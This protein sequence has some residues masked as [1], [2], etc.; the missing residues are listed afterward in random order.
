MGL[1]DT[2]PMPKKDP[3][4]MD[5]IA[6]YDGEEPDAG[7]SQIK[8]SVDKVQKLGVRTEPAAMRALDKVVKAVGRIEV[9]ER[10]VFA[11]RAQVRRL[12]GA[13]VRQRHR[14]AGQQGPAAV[15]GLQPGTG[16]RAARICDRH[17]GG[18][19]AE[20]RRRRSAGRHEAPRRLEPGPAARTGTSPK[21]RCARW[22][23][24]GRRGARS[25]SARRCP[26]SSWKRRPSRACASCPATASTR[27]PICRRCGSWRTCTNRT[28]LWC[29]T[30]SKAKISIGA[31][32]D[33]SV[34]GHDHLRLSDAEA[35]D[36]N[37][38]RCGW[39]SPIRASC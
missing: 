10:R 29:R 28:S 22:P 18:Q 27:S 32:P 8:I 4:G 34:R 17:R 39:K 5:Y 35:R 25:R 13:A 38:V 24:P 1:P 14:P 21:S 16:V 7:S 26:A 31:Y 30:G 33:Q 20:G 37:R 9:D 6:V 3:M 12:G 11:D 36:P 19:G 23:N 15:R 2:S